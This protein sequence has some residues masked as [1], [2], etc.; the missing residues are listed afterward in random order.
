MT[1]NLKELGLKTSR[2]KTGTPPRIIKKSIKW[3]ELEKQPGDKIPSPFSFLTKEI[4]LKQ[5]DCAITR[6]TEQT[7]DLIDKSLK[8]SPVYSG[9]IQS[10]GLDIA[11]QL[12]IKF[13]SFQIDTHT[14]FF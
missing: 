8:L 12:R 5:I 4:T 2:L 7:H 1:Q 10:R 13:I 6:T 14:K 3:E 11:R 9:S